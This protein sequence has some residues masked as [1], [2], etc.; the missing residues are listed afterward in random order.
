MKK[1]SFWHAYSTQFQSFFYII[2]FYFIYFIFKTWGIA[3][4]SALTLHLCET[5]NEIHWHEHVQFSYHYYHIPQSYNNLI[6]DTEGGR[7]R[8]RGREG[9]G[10]EGG[11]GRRGRRK[12]LYQERLKGYSKRLF[13]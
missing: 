1:T 11:G 12:V 8:K 13:Q 2:Y 9:A 5:N 7:E 6:K 10:E 3:V 4:F